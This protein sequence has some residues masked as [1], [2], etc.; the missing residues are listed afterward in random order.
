MRRT[1]ILTPGNIGEEIVSQ[2]KSWQEKFEERVAKQQAKRGPLKEGKVF[3]H[4]PAKFL[5]IFIIG[6]VVI[7]HLAILVVMMQSGMH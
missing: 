7:T 5:F 1:Q 4:G 2:E 6:F 3:E